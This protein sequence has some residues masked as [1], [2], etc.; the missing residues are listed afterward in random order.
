[1]CD[2]AYKPWDTVVLEAQASVCR[3]PIA[4][5]PCRKCEPCRRVWEDME[6]RAEEADREAAAAGSLT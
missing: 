3:A 1:M 4:D 2:P 5:V 6:W